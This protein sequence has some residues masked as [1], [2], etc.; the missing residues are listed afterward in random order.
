MH[1]G[2]TAHQHVALS[3]MPSIVGEGG[4]GAARWRSAVAGTAD[5]HN[6]A[7]FGQ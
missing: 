5:P 4:G 1:A 7:R 6:S 2:T 3:G